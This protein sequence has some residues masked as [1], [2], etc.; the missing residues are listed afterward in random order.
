M[1]ENISSLAHRLESVILRILMANGYEIVHMDTTADIIALE[2]DTRTQIAIEVK[3]YRSSEVGREVLRNAGAQIARYKKALATKGMLVATASLGERDRTLLRHIGVDEIW[4]INEIRQ[5]AAVDPVLISELER[6]FRDAELQNASTPGS[7]S[8]LQEPPSQPEAE[9]E[10]D[11]LIKKLQKTDAGGPDA[12]KFEKLC[13]ECIQ[14]LFGEQLG[15]LLPQNRVEHG[16]QYMDLIARLMPDKSAAFWVSLAQDFRCRYVVFEFK[17]Y[18]DKISQ[19]QVY[20]TEKYLYPNAL[21]PVAVIIARNGC[22]LGANRATQGALRES[23]KVIL[24]LS[25][26]D[27]FK[28]LRAKDGGLEPSD[29]LIDH[30]DMLLTTIA[31]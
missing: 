18:S 23:G 19:N 10:G 6:L 17:N 4:D 22:D 12:H 3:L 14:Y 13:C 27:L 7:P 28:L 21:R 24:L 2:P 1:A 25:L 20:T 29:L 15:Q 11:Q 5:H 16:F 30:L 8:N 9:P 31:P 26:E